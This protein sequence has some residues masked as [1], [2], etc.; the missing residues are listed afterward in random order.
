MAN[1][2]LATYGRPADAQYV[3][4]ARVGS[5]VT[6]PTSVSAT[7]T[8]FSDA[9]LVTEDGI[10]Q[11]MDLGVGDPLKDWNKKSILVPEADPSATVEIRL[12][13]QTLTSLGIVYGAANVTGTD[14]TGLSY[15]FDG[16]TDNF[17]I[18]IDELWN[19][20][21]GQ[22]TRAHRLVYPSAKLKEISDIDHTKD[23]AV[24]YDCTFEATVDTSGF[25]FYGYVGAATPTQAAAGGAAGG[26]A[27]GGTEGGNGGTSGGNGGTEG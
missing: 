9:G 18:V 17:I 5:G 3:S 13:S 12:M 6:I 2:K 26:A 11:G 14:A 7:L 19:D 8:G 4:I 22:P 15:K 21:N 1:E 23:G 10:T 20:T 16:T 25:Y 24:I 27:A